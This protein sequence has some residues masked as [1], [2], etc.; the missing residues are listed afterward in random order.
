MR[1]MVRE[2]YLGGTGPGRTDILPI[3]VGGGSY[4]LPADH[5]AAIGQGNNTAGAAKISQMFG[6]GP[7][8]MPLRHFSGHITQPRAPTMGMRMP[9]MGSMGTSAT[10]LGK[11]GFAVGGVGKPTKIIAA[12]GEYVLSPE[13][14]IAKY[15]SLEKGH[16]ALDKWVME[17]RKKHI[18]TLRNLKPPKT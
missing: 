14:I 4:V 13:Q 15:G 6:S 2:G 10:S 18:K 7:G 16:R 5:L 8:G 1:Q 9:K 11:I 3:T 12:H 17:T